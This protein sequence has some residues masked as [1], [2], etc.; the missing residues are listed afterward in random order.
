MTSRDL[1]YSKIKGSTTFSLRFHSLI[2]KTQQ[3][4]R[5]LKALVTD[6]LKNVNSIVDVQGII[7]HNALYQNF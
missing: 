1:F 3:S 6:K 4:E 7:G 5:N 2:E